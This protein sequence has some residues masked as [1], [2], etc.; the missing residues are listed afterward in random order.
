MEM[1][2]DDEMQALFILSSLPDSWATLVVSLSN[3]A[4]NGK[5]NLSMVKDC[6]LNEEER[7]RDALVTENRGRQGH[8]GGNKGY[9]NRSKIRAA[10]GKSKGEDDSKD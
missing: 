2:L 7:R 10:K 5:L 1:N 4:P 3:S 6:M 8:K 9:K